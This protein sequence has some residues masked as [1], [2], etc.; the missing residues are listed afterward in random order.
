MKNTSKMIAVTA[1]TAGLLVGGG[2]WGYQ[3]ATVD[4][5]AAQAAGEKGKAATAS[6]A[7]TVQVTQSG[8][9]LEVAKAQFDGNFID[10]S[11]NRS[12][13]ELKSS[14]VHKGTKD[15]GSAQIE[16]GSLESIDGFIDGKSIIEL[17]GGGLGQR[18]GLKWGSGETPE[19]ARVL[20]KDASWLG[21]KGYTFPEKFQLKL[22]VK[23][24]GVDK[25]Y[26]V[27]LPM[28]KTADKPVV[29]TDSLTKQAGNLTL[30]LG[31][32]SLTSTSTRVQLIA[33]GDTTER[34]FGMQ[35][36]VVDD[37]GRQLD[38]LTAFGTDDNNKE[39]A[40]YNDIV[41]TPIHSDAK[42]I[43][44]KPFYPEMEAPGA[45]NGA[46]KLDADGKIVKNYIEELEM[47]VPLK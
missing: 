2:A 24:T 32:I 30:K 35:Y 21:G 27:E 41:L 20:L 12:G 23:L 10:I 3:A 42:F 46:F 9:T 18:P 38:Y 15:E 44:I 25:P 28:Q 8:I 33:K 7:K 4:A 26:I 6:K 11:L 36:E 13:K 45:A 1:L 40:L 22:K 34:L 19:S 16:H 29:L 14:F 47:K 31:K 37:S 5:A 17:G 43:T 39:K